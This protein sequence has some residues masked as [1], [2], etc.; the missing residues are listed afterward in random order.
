M[1]R[2]RTSERQ[3]DRTCALELRGAREAGVLALGRLAVRAPEGG[4]VVAFRIRARTCCSHTRAPDRSSANRC[5][6]LFRG[7]GRTRPGHHHPSASHCPI[8]VDRQPLRY[9]TQDGT[10]GV[11]GSPSYGEAKGRDVLKVTTALA[12]QVLTEVTDD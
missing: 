5:R 12:T 2:R 7:T 8:A 6:S 10:H 11:S 1:L 4:V 9:H 3:D